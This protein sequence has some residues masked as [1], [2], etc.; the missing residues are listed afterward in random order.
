MCSRLCRFVSTLAV[1]V[2]MVLSLLG[3]HTFERE[4][5]RDYQ[6]QIDEWHEQHPDDK[7]D[8]GVI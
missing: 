8:G 1:V 5:L 2:T 6:K 3:W 4:N 7:I